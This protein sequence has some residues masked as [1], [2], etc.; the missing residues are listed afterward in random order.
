G[1]TVLS[2]VRSVAE[3]AAEFDR[4]EEEVI[5]LLEDARR[6]M[7]EVRAKRVWPGTDDKL[8][9]DWTALAISAF[10]LAGRVLDE[11]RYEAAARE[12]ADRI[13]GNAVRD[14]RLLHRPPPRPSPGG[15]GSSQGISGFATDYAFFIEALLDLYEA[16]FEPRY[17]SQAV[18]LQR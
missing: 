7:Y 4:S 3:L 8:L 12:A 5:T 17:F 14:G 18:R 10:A 11:P 13:V 16:T 2:V 6:K 9:T 1:E 15:E